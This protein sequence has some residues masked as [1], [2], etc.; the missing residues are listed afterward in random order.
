MSLDTEELKKT[1]WWLMPNGKQPGKTAQQL[2]FLADQLGIG[3]KIEVLTV[4]AAELQNQLAAAKKGLENVYKT[5][6]PYLPCEDMWD[7]DSWEVQ[8]IRETEK[9]LK[10]LHQ[11]LSSTEGE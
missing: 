8:L 7:E 3:G 10:Q 11:H 9:V 2:K 4:E 6:S 5:I 1:A